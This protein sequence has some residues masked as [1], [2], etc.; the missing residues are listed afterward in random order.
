MFSC[1]N[2][3]LCGNELNLFVGLD[4]ILGIRPSC[5]TVPRPQTYACKILHVQ[6]TFSS[7]SVIL[8]VTSFGSLD[9]CSIKHTDKAGNLYFFHGILR[10]RMQILNMVFVKM[11]HP[12]VYL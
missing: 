4:P 3:T 7:D 1:S 8:F 2:Q 10:I 9:G 11:L 5:G 6:Y 12:P